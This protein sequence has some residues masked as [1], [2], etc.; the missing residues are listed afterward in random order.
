MRAEVTPIVYCRETQQ[1]QVWEVFQNLL[2]RMDAVGVEADPRLPNGYGKIQIR[3]IQIIK[4]TAK[5]PGIFCP[6]ESVFCNSGSEVREVP[7][8]S[9][10]LF[11]WNRL[12]AWCQHPAQLGSS[13]L[14]T[15]RVEWVSI[16]AQ[17]D[18]FGYMQTGKRG[19]AAVGKG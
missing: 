11:S 8:T 15:Q 9:G 10:Y 5:V 3:L 16:A 19:D 13:L 1:R 2:R 6:S 17:T 18:V 14:R 4:Y 12:T 7:G